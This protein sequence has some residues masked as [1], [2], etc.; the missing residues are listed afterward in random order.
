MAWGDARTRILVHRFLTGDV[1]KKLPAIQFVR[2]RAESIPIGEKVYYRMRC[3]EALATCEIS[4]R[5]HYHP[6]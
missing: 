4:L 2:I 3:Q 1:V 5:Y 6:L